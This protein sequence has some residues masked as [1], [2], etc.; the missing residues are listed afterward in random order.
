MNVIDPKKFYNDTMPS[1]FGGD[2]ENARW[3][4]SAFVEFAKLMLMS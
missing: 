1:K 2:Y 3:H 4:S